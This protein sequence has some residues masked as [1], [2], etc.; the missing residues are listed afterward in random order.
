[1][2][3]TLSAGLADHPGMS[4]NK[5]FSL[6][7]S[8]D[9]LV[10][11]YFGEQIQRHHTRSHPASALGYPST[12]S[13]IDLYQPRPATAPVFDNRTLEQML[14]PKRQLPFP[15]PTPAK[16]ARKGTVKPD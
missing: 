1:M 10:S 9:G 3:P 14:P 5:S 16:K 4:S 13:S 15:I 11:G 2:K 12:H 8:A 6:N 7:S